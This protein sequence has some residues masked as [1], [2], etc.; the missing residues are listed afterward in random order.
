MTA[1][2]IRTMPVIRAQLQSGGT[3]HVYINGTTWASQT[4]ASV[5]TLVARVA[6]GSAIS[7]RCRCD[8]PFEGI[9]QCHNADC[10]QWRG[11]SHG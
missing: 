7:F 8:S 10:P 3:W 2:S 11:P 5:R 1:E 4:Q 6:P 9:G